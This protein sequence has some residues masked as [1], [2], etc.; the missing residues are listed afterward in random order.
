[1]TEPILQLHFTG[2]LKG[3]L[4]K[5]RETGIV[6][7]PLNRRASI[8]DIIEALGIP[9][10][11]VGRITRA[12]TELGFDYLPEKDTVIQVAPFNDDI[13]VTMPSLLRPAPFADHTFL[14]DINVL[15]LGRD[16]RMIGF[17]A[18]DITGTNLQTIAQQATEEQRIVLTRNR[19]LLKINAINYGQLLRSEDHQT[20]LVEVLERYR[21]FTQIK[22]FSRCLNCNG[23]LVNVDKNDILHL[24]EPLTKKYYSTFKQCG[25][26]N[27]VYWR[28]SHHKKMMQ[29]ID[30]I[31]PESPEV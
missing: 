5:S 18:T 24:L 27:N 26:C 8:K 20:Q 16:L 14:I 21:L 4:R 28:G 29:L 23:T 17:D 22:P 10:T 3:L 1:M 11:E 19:E 9:H 6:Y 31:Q 13:S 30:S 15:K 7:Y 12:E 2:N 25:H